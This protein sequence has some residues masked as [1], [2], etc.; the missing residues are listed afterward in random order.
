MKLVEIVFRIFVR[1]L[2]RCSNSVKLQALEHLHLFSK[3][4]TI[5]SKRSYLSNTFSGFLCR[6]FQGS[7]T[8]VEQCSVRITFPKKLFAQ[9]AYL[10]ILP[11]LL[12][13]AELKYFS[14]VSTDLVAIDFVEH[15]LEAASKTL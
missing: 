14:T 4:L 5:I 2:L 3:N 15:L 11:A 9:K 1:Y 6:T 10:R 12:L 8:T 7:G 13:K